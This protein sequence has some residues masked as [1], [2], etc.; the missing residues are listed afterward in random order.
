MFT[1]EELNIIKKYL[2]MAEATNDLPKGTTNCVIDNLYIKTLPPKEDLMSRHEVAN[3][4]SCSPKNVDRL[5]RIGKLKKAVPLRKKSYCKQDI[6]Q[7]I[8]SNKN[9]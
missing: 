2:L 7:F 4:L 9:I 5:V 6:I 1:L 3:Y 8:Q